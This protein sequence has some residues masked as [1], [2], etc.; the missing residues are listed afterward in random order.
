MY[1]YKADVLYDIG[2]NLFGNPLLKLFSDFVVGK[3]LLKLDRTLVPVPRRRVLV[4]N[5]VVVFAFGRQTLL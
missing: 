4:V 1:E 2:S 3:W 5:E